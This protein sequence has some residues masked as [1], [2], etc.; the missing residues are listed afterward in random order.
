MPAHFGVYES[1]G[2]DFDSLKLGE[3]LRNPQVIINEENAQDTKDFIHKRITAIQNQ[4]K[5]GEL[6]DLALVIG[7]WSL[8]CVVITVNAHWLP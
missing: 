5:T 7:G 6:E 4:R 1:G 3:L 2:F 8:A